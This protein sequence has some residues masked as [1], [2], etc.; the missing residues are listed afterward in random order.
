MISFEIKNKMSSKL[1]LI[2]NKAYI[3]VQMIVSQFNRINNLIFLPA[4]I[5]QI[6]SSI[7][8]LSNEVFDSKYM[9]Q[10]PSKAELQRFINKEMNQ[11][12]QAVK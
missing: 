5:S 1:Q 3:P 11:L 4:S 9:I 6:K 2:D 10:L 8:C 12:K 7:A